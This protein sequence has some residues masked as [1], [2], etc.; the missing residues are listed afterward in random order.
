MSEANADIKQK[1]KFYC[2]L[3]NFR[4]VTTKQEKEEFIIIDTTKKEKPPAKIRFIGNTTIVGLR[5]KDLGKERLLDGEFDRHIAT[6]F[7][8]KYG[9]LPV[10]EI[11]D[12]MQSSIV[13]FIENIVLALRLFREGDVFCKIIWSDRDSNFSVLTSAYELPNT[14]FFKKYELQVDEIDA[15]N[16]IFQKINKTDFSKRRT[17][18]IALDR[19][20]RSYG[21]S[22]PDEKIID[23][24]IAF[25]ALF[26]RDNASNHG[27]VIGTACSLLMG[28]TD[29]ERAEI[30]D[31]FLKTYAL[32]NKIV[33]GSQIDIKGINDTVLKLEEYLRKAI[34]LLI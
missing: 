26:L 5:K 17:L 15:V 4:I 22:M 30:Y 1:P 11:F 3:F 14:I 21:K 34:L 31:F 19:L 7:Y 20:S 6:A 27:L 12:E 29:K 9:Y 2:P 25:E 33:H 24:M 13:Q 8:D 23:S 16:E 28:K 10:I 32:R 18:K